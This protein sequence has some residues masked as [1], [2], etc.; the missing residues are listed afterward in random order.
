MTENLYAVGRTRFGSRAC[1]SMPQRCKERSEL[2]RDFV[3]AASPYRE[4]VPDVSFT[5][6]RS[7]PLLFKD[8]VVERRYRKAMLPA[9]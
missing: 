7:G 2:H 4:T 6:L 3:R 5:E 8:A 9:S 1:E